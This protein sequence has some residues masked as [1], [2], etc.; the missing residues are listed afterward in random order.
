[1]NITYEDKI[2]VDISI[3]NITPEKRNKIMQLLENKDYKSL[4]YSSRFNTFDKT[5]KATLRVGFILEKTKKSFISE[6]FKKVME[7]E[8]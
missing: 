5:N 8:I 1:M 2:R 6:L 7:G 3:N 4:N